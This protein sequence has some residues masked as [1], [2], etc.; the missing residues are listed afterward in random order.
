MTE[1]E[2]TTL[3]LE[4]RSKVNIDPAICRI[5]ARHMIAFVACL[6]DTQRQSVMNGLEALFREIEMLESMA[7]RPVPRRSLPQADPKPKAFDK[8]VNFITLEWLV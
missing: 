8:F 1:D 7:K 2:L 4:N 6:T 3:L 5:A